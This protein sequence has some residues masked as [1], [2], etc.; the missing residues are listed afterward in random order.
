M[1]RGAN[2]F[3]SDA[4]FEGNPRKC[5]S[6]QTDSISNAAFDSNPQECFNAQSDSIH[7]AE[8]ERMFQCANKSK[9]IA[10][11]DGNPP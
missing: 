4:V 6:A 9:A 10:L 3:N 11:I 2:K 8:S 5:F 7:S 1:F